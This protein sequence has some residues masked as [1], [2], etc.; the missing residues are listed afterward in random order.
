MR[1]QKMIF[2][3]AWVSALLLLNGVALGAEIFPTKPLELVVPFAAGGGTDVMCRTAVARA[4][5]F[6]NNQPIVVVNK[7]GAATVAAS[8]YV[9]GGRNDG[10]TLYSTSTSS[11]MIVPLMQKTDFSWKDFIGIAQVLRGGDGLFVRADFPYHTLEKFIEYAKQNPGKIK[12]SSAGTGSTTHLA[13]EGLAAAVGIDIRHIPTK[14][15]AEAV[16]AILGGHVVAAS[17]SLTPY[18][19]HVESQ[20]LKC[21]AQYGVER[22]KLFAQFPT[23]KDQGID[24][25]VDLW[26]WVVVPK[27]VPADRIKILAAAFKSMLHDKDTV[28]SLEKVGNPVSY[29]SPEG[30]ENVMK[31]SEVAIARLLKISKMEAK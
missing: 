30:Y 31:G 9:L 25:V 18:M 8:K 7:T 21:L 29:L 17:G 16:T 27:D 12:Y 11:M 24:V 2:R 22:D 4:A 15:D 19:P 6:L 3:I 5:P 23:F 20:K 14:G 13:M 26:R 1:N 28:A 10:Y